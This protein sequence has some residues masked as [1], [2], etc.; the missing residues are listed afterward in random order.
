MNEVFKEELYCTF[1]KDEVLL[2]LEMI[3]SFKM[4]QPADRRGR[5]SSLS[6][7]VKKK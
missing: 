3:S 5:K 1:S 2:A 4:K 7:N 6:N